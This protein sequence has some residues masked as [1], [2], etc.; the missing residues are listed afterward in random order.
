MTIKKNFCLTNL[1]LATFF[2]FFSNTSLASS[3]CTSAGDFLKIDNNNYLAV[4]SK[5]GEVSILDGARE[6][7]ARYR[8]EDDGKA[9]L[10]ME[11]DL[12]NNRKVRVTGKYRDFS[13]TLSG[14][15]ISFYKSYKCN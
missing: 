7:K 13:V 8:F 2:G 14:P 4:F 11:V 6:F 15:G 10:N 5:T 3:G 12:E 9:V 1:I